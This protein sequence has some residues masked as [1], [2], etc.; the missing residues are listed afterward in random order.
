MA[1]IVLET[2]GANGRATQHKRWNLEEPIRKVHPH[3]QTK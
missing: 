2:V 1:P 3:Y